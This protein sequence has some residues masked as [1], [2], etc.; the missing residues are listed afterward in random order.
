MHAAGGGAIVAMLR[1]VIGLMALTLFI[2]LAPVIA[3]AQDIAHLGPGDRVTMRVLA[4][5][6]LDLE[7]QSYDALG[8]TYTIAAD[9]TLALPLLKP[10]RA[11]DM[12]LPLLAELVGDAYRIRLGLSEPPAAMLEIADYRPVFIL[13]D[14]ARP[15]RYDYEPGLTP[16]QALALAGGVYRENGASGAEAIRAMGTLREVRLDQAR[17]RMRAARLRAEMEGRPAF[18]RPALPAHPGGDTADDAL[19]QSERDLFT[20]RRDQLHR[21]LASIDETRDLLDTEIQALEGKRVGITR[22][23]ALVRESLGNLEVLRERGLARSPALLTLQGTLIDLE[24][25]ELDTE[26]G[27]FRARQQL[28]ELDRDAGEIEAARRVQVLQ[29]L[30]ATEAELLRLDTRE[31]TTQSVLTLSEALLDAQDD[32]AETRLEFSVVRGTGEA[33]TRFDIDDSEPLLPLDVLTVRAISAA[34]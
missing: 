8:G 10:I 32:I 31:A 24:A 21:A 26:T 14:V 7:F 1:S 19:F 33:Q 18:A 17:E 2:T 13:G 29:E 20:G 15:G 25:R 23:L 3:S 30:L 12:P 22:Q 34:E 5:N 28:S 6:T 9:G 27:I 16:L 11:A 4:W